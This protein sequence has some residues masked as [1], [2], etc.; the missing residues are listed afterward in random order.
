MKKIAITTTEGGTTKVKLSKPTDEPRKSKLIK[1]TFYLNP[2][3]NVN[4]ER[5]KLR[6][7]EQGQNTNKSE[8][9]Q[10]AIGLLYEK[11]KK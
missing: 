10:E 2:E 4:L 5:V 6:L 7:K 3:D 11:Y 9:I 1:V 8:L